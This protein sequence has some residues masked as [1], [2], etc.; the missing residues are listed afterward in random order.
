MQLKLEHLILFVNDEVSMVGYKEFQTMNQT[1]CTI[2]GTTDADWG[3][4]MCT[5]VG[6]LYQLPP[7][8]NTQYIC[9]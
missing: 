8:D 3:E 9:L 5:A 1:M 4:Y 7:M 2:K 6:D